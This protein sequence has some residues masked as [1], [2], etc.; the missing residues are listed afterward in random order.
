M[1]MKDVSIF[2]RFRP[3]SLQSRIRAC[4]PM[5]RDDSG[6]ALIELAFIVALLGLPLVLGTTEMGVLVY[7]SIEISNAAYVGASFAMQSVT[8]AENT[9]GITSAAQADA[10]E[11]GTSLTVTPTTYYVCATALGGTQYTGTNAQA[12][13]TSACTGS[14]NSAVEMVQV[15]TSA[16][17]K[18]FLHAPGLASTFTFSGTSVAEVEQ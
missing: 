9:S 5:L 4:D 14:G 2:H 3:A 8:N 11:F 12:N 7:D 6:S 13:A 16:L 10:P 17:V 18:P 1:K 15:T